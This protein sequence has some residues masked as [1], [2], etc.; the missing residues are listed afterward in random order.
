M[1]SGTAGTFFGNQTGGGWGGSEEGRGERL[2][3]DEKGG[4]GLREVTQWNVPVLGSC[5]AILFPPPV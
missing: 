3:W 1:I 4:R 5:A 2:G